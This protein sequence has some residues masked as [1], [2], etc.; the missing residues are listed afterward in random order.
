MRDVC[1]ARAS[2]RPIQ[3]SS[4]AIRASMSRLLLLLLLGG[5]GAAEWQTRHPRRRPPLQ[6]HGALRRG[7]GVL[8]EH[9]GVLGAA[10]LG[11]VDDHRA[12]AQ[13]DPRQPA[14]DDVDVLAEDR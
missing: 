4:W 6:R 2:W 12:L 11:G 7:L 3:Y 14:R 8:L 10:A 1:S 5:P 13:R 9:P